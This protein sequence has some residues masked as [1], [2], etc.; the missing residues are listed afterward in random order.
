M[1]QD[2]H[3]WLHHLTTH[4]DP[5]GTLPAT[6]SQGAEATDLV[7]HELWPLAGRT[8]VRATD[9]LLTTLTTL[10]VLPLAWTAPQ[11]LTG[12]LAVF[13]SALA[14]VSGAGAITTSS[15]KGL[16]DPL[17]TPEGRR[18]LVVG[19]MA[20]FAVG[21]AVGFAAGS[22]YGS[23][24][25][26]AAGFAVGS[27]VGVAVWLWAW[28]WLVQQPS[29]NFGARALIRNDALV[30]L[31]FALTGA[32]TVGLGIGLE[33]GLLTGSTYGLGVGLAVGLAGGP[34]A[35]AIGGVRASRR[36]AVFLLCSRGRLP[37]RLG[38]FLDWAVTAGLM[39]YSGPAYQYRHRELQHW[40]RQHPQPA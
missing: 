10:T 9:A 7:L 8:R 26:F 25:G 38:L 4:L 27:T 22:T 35:G 14:A 33:V 23:T 18:K 36:Y 5:T 32:L 11:G 40:L 2:V 13:I 24:A 17:R 3:R 31:T 28:A 29:A 34:M 39:R 15:P 16:P 20:G 12:P 19:L 37:F 21:L 1:P 30:G 6:A